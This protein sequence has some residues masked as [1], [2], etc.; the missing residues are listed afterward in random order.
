MIQPGANDRIVFMDARET[1]VEDAIE[2]CNDAF[3]IARHDERFRRAA[4]PLDQTI[5]ASPGLRDWI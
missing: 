4:P 3:S 2:A 5:C 1:L